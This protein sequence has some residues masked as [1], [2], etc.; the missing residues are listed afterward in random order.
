MLIRFLL[1]WLLVA[2][3]T[4]ETTLAYSRRTKCL[5]YYGVYILG[6]KM[7]WLSAREE[8]LK[9]AGRELHLVE[10]VRYIERKNGLFGAKSSNRTTYREYY[11]VVAEGP[12][13]K[14]ELQQESDGSVATT[15]LERKD[16]VYWLQRP[17]LSKSKITTPRHNLR[18]SQ[19][20]E[21]WTRQ[22]RAGQKR[23][24][25]VTSLEQDPLEHQMSF[26]FTGTQSLVWGGLATTA[27]GVKFKEEGMSGKALL[28]DNGQLWKL[29]SGPMEIRAEPKALAQKL[30]K[31][32]DMLAAASIRVSKNLGHPSKVSHLRLKAENFGDFSFP[33]SPR[34]KLEEN[35]VLVLQ[36]DRPDFPPEP[37]SAVEKKV[38]L[39][40]TDSIV[41]ND[42]L[43]KLSRLILAESKGNNLERAGLLQ[44]W[45]YKKLSKTYSK[46]AN[47]ALQVLENR[48]GDCTEHTILFVSLARSAGIP[49]REVGGLIYLPS[50]LGGGTFAWHAWGE[51]YTGRRWV[52]VDPTFDE[53]LVDATHI[54]MSK[55]PNDLGWM[56]VMGKLK[57]TVLD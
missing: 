16:G 23:S 22:A 10:T 41:V 8:N 37:L 55:K 30:D 54:K 51:I 50:L 42:R 38:N 26:E 5:N 11:E 48:A 9:L 29:E 28:W 33:Q 35:K 15:K 24:Q 36:R 2:P 19:Q 17:G 45:V 56:Q 12:L 14:A 43:R 4:A 44:H 32:V 46:N 27:Y 31:S 49:A 7:G 3:C 39:E 1:L 47:N 40:S 25:W 20:M 34:Q 57:L 53:T 13:F 6:R 21:G 52:G 18:E